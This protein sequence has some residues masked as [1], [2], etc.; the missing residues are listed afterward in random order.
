METTKELSPFAGRLGVEVVG[1]MGGCCIESILEWRPQM[2]GQMNKCRNCGSSMKTIRPTEFAQMAFNGQFGRD[3][4]EVEEPKVVMGGIFFSQ[5]KFAD[6][7]AVKSWMEK[8]EVAPPA[9]ILPIEEYAF[10]V[11]IERIL[12][13]STRFVYAGAGVL[14]EVG[15]AEKQVATGGGQAS[16]S[17][18]GITTTS[19]ATGGMSSPV[20][21]A[22]VAGASSGTP[23]LIKGMTEFNDGHQHEYSLVPM[24]EGGGWRV[25][26]F[27]S[28]NNGH[29]HMVECGLSETMALDTR[30][31]PD[32]A[33][34][35]GHAHAHRI[36]WDGGPVSATKVKDEE[37]NP[38]RA[39]LT[40]AIERAK[41]KAKE[42]VDG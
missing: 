35:G 7:E 8:H 26:G 29:T 42:R 18:P 36:A 30:T 11:P 41:G 27:T 31:A 39:Q 32:Q 33:P 23:S 16:M 28:F 22:V 21:S 37:E 12:P 14:A 1:K 17:S 3:H 5:K 4:S 20:P 10:Y 6:V 19:M 13:E 2:L 38:F 34:V 15:V 40:A 25:K 9:D 24:P